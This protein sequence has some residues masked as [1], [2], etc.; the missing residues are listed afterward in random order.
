MGDKQGHSEGLF[1]ENIRAFKRPRQPFLNNWGKTG[2]K[3][4]PI[5]YKNKQSELGGKRYGEC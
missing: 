3:K 1:I 4:K 5:K 2:I